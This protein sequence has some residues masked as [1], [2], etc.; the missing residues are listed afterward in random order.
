MIPEHLEPECEG[1]TILRNVGGN[2]S[3]NMTQ[4]PGRLGSPSVFLTVITIFCTSSKADDWP[5]LFSVYLVVKCTQHV[6]LIS[7]P[8][9]EYYCRASAHNCFTRCNSSA[10]ESTC[11]SM[12]SG[13]TTALHS[14][15]CFESFP[16]HTRV[17]PAISKYCTSGTAHVCMD[18]KHTDC[19]KA[20]GL[21]WAAI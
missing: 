19:S 15:L 3:V 18:V 7:P 2:S 4:H 9:T 17:E 10:C 12:L 6:C 11:R 5:Y 20:R 21:L 1:I 13:L 14:S 8:N 16:L